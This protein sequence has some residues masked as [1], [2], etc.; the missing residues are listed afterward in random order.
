MHT[1]LS[2]RLC[3]NII[4]SYTGSAALLFFMIMRKKNHNFL[5]ICKRSQK[6]QVYDGGLCGAV[7]G[8]LRSPY[9]HDG[10]L[11]ALFNPFGHQ[12]HNITSFFPYFFC[13]SAFGNGSIFRNDDFLQ[14]LENLYS[15]WKTIYEPSHLNW[16]SHNKTS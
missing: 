16:R 15:N 11:Y 14:T 13:I 5:I 2:L 8:P 3:S 9:M 12:L 1:S 6:A 4:I 7:V 10:T